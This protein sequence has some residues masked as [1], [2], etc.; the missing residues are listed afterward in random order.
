MRHRRWKHVCRPSRIDDHR[1]EERVRTF[2]NRTRV[3]PHA[4]DSPEHS[5]VLLTLK[6]APL[7]RYVPR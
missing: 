7:L 3:L 2:A 6:S 1:A 5:E 4:P